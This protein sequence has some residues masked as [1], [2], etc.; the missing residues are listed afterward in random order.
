MAKVLT[1][2]ATVVCSH[3]S[4]GTV[5]VGDGQAALKVDGNAVLVKGDVVGKTISDCNVQTTNTTSPC[6]TA[7]LLAAG[8]ATKLKVKG[9]SVLLATATGA[10]DSVPPGTWSV[11]KAGQAKLD[12]T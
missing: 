11:T 4:S 1:T 12:A 10:T 2:A 6:T 5:K 8:E 7:G 9:K 3:A